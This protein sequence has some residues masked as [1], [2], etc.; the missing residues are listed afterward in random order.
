MLLFFFSLDPSVTIRTKTRRGGG[1]GSFTI[2]YLP[3][4]GYL[5]M[6]SGESERE[7]S[8]ASV[9]FYTINPN[10]GDARARARAAIPAASQV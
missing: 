10:V 2:V 6:A 5:A 9:G 3:D 8:A 7:A 1:E 4:V